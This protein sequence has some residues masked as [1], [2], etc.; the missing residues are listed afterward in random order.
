MIYFVKEHI[1][2]Q[3]GIPETITTDYG[4]MFTSGE[5]GGFATS[6]GIKILNST[7]YYAQAN[8]QAEA[9]NKGVIKLIKMKIEEQ[10]RC[11]Y[12]TLNEALWA[13]R[14]ACH[15]S[16]KL[17]PYQLVYGH[18]AVLPWELKIGSRC[19]MFQDQLT[20][21]DYS[22]LMKNELQDFSGY[23]L[24]ALISVEENK[25]RIARWYDKKVKVKEFSQGDLVWK[26]IL[27]I[28]SKGP[29]FGK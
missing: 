10:P 28:G 29:K 25:K 27:P 12:T 1:V 15:G 13:Y 7:P 2:Y 6:M 3:L 26:L 23:R 24:R 20:A 19:T 14:M 22:A 16:T 18:E 8:G 9:A 4:T 5:F 11:W 21:D 17:S